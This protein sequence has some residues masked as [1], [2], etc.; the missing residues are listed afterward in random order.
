MQSPVAGESSSRRPESAFLAL[1]NELILS[2]LSF[3]SST[4]LVTLKQTCKAFRDQQFSDEG[5]EGSSGPP[6]TGLQRAAKEAVLR[7]CGQ[8][9]CRA[10]RWR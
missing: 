10:S 1:P 6:L 3:C 7:L 2:I 5:S 4:S 8:D 9:L